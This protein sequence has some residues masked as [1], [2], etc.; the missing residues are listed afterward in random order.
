MDMPEAVWQ[1]S[2]SLDIL[3]P[4]TQTSEDRK[5]LLIFQDELSKYTEA[6]PIPQQD[7]MT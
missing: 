2:S 3:G 4:L 6:V 5:Y 7:A 1:N